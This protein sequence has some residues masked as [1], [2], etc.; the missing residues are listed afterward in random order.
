LLASDWPP[1]GAYFDYGPAPR[2]V[3]E[4]AREFARTAARHGATLPQLAM[5]FPLRHAATAS[6][7][8][9]MRTPQQV[10]S[11]IER[12]GAGLSPQLWAAIEAEAPTSA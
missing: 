6:V 9:G 4:L 11:T 8:A 3:V 7:V 5:Q 1:D 2:D 10:R 12:A